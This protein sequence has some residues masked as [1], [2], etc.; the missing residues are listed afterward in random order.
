VLAGGSTGNYGNNPANNKRAVDIENLF[1]DA[2][3]Y[4]KKR[5][6]G[7]GDSGYTDANGKPIP[8]NLYG[9]PGFWNSFIGALHQFIL[10]HSEPLVFDLGS[11]IQTTALA[12]G[13][14]FDNKN[15]GFAEETAWVGSNTGILVDDPTGGPI[16]NGSQ[17]FGTSTSLSG[18]GY[19]VDGFAALYPVRPSWTVEGKSVRW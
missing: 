2:L 9:N 12:N 1:T 3:G 8:I 17:L 10:E 19:A 7:Q 6:S 14:F 13:T 5:Y 15:D 18:G 11:G 16:T 4:T